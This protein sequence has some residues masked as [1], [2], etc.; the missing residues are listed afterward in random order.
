MF[1][2]GR[3]PP[4]RIPCLQV[5]KQMRMC[6]RGA[7][8]SDGLNVPAHIQQA[9][10]GD[11]LLSTSYQVKEKGDAGLP[12]N[13]ETPGNPVPTDRQAE[14]RASIEMSADEGLI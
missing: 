12:S 14:A 6:S 4:F 9:R 2:R 8:T 1:G 5:E 10:S 7:E 13:S 3:A 11:S